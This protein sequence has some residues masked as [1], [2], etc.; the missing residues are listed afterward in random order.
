MAGKHDKSEGV[1]I[2]SCSFPKFVYIGKSKGVGG[3]LRAAK[4][5]LNNGKF[6]N[7][8]MQLQFNKTPTNFTFHE[9]E[10]LGS[11]FNKD[12]DTLI[13]LTD[14]IRNEWLDKGYVPY[15]D[16]N[17]IE[18]EP[19]TEEVDSYGIDKLDYQQRDIIQRILDGFE[20]GLNA[21]E[22]SQLLASKGI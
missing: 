17:I 15:N 5:K 2:I 12:I 22:L 1:F 4:S 14:T 11:E 16:L 20:E 6:H 19:D 7:K 10:L 8:E 18:L 3:A 13:I 9:L 21:Q